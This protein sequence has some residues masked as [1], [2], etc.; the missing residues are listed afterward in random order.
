MQPSAPNISKWFLE[1]AFLSGL[2]LM[3]TSDV[4]EDRTV[5][6]CF[7]LVEVRFAKIVM[8]VTHIMILI[9]G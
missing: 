9:N 3:V 2:T 8:V 6:L 7:L 4:K 1:L 5:K